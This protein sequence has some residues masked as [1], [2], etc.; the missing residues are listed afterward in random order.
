MSEEIKEEEQA[1][2]FEYTFEYID[3]SEYI[4]SAYFA[5]AC[6]EDI[7]LGMAS[8]AFKK[9]INLIRNNALEIVEHCLKN[10]HDNLFS[11]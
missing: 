8:P 11:E 1:E 7:D 3:N 9:R 4:Q 6:I 2:E 10:M 5:L